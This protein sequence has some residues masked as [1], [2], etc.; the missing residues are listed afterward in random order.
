MAKEQARASVPHFLAKPKVRPLR[1]LSFESG[2]ADVP[3]EHRGQPVAAQG[4]L[5]SSPTGF[6][7]STG[8]SIGLSITHNYSRSLLPARKPA[9]SKVRS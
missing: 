5:S 9:T 3:G 4:G 8:G 2:H 7:Q 6:A 1:A